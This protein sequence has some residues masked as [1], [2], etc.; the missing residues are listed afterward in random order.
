MEEA[1]YKV[2]SSDDEIAAICSHIRP[3]A[4]AQTDTLPFVVYQITDED[5]S[6]DYIDEPCEYKKCTVQIDV[7]D[8]T[9]AGAKTLSNIIKDKLHYLDEVIEVEDEEGSVVTSWDL[10]ILHQTSQDLT[11]PQEPGKEKPPFRFSSDYGVMY[12]EV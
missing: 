11:P 7:Y 3:V 4:L 5:N 2:L 10:T 9:Y 6:L 8:D 12:K 1:L